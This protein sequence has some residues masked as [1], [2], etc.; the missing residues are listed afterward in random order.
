MRHFG[1]FLGYSPEQKIRKEGLGRLLAFIIN[2]ATS[3]DD[4]KLTIAC[5][6]WFKSNLLE[7]LDEHDIDPSE[8]RIITT[9][10]LPIGLKLRYS[11][12]AFVDYLLPKK[13]QKTKNLKAKLCQKALTIF[14]EVI[15]NSSALGYLFAIVVGIVLLI[16]FIL[17]LPLIFVFLILF[18]LKGIF[19]RRLGFNKILFKLKNILFLPLHNIKNNRLAI[20]LHETMRRKELNRLI[21]AINIEPEIKAWLIPTLFWPEVE[22]IKARKVIVAPDIVMYDFPLYFS[23]EMSSLSLKRLER[24][25][26]VAD[27]FITYSEYVRDSHLIMRNGVNYQDV[28]VIGHGRVDM[29]N[30]LTIQGKKQ[31]KSIEN[32]VAKEILIKFRDSSLGFNPHWSSVEFDKINY[33]FYSSQL[34][35]YKNI[36]ILLKLLTIL[37]FGKNI[38][39]KLIVTSDLYKDS[40]MVSYIIN[41]KLQSKVLSAYDIPSEVLAAFNALATLSV[42]PTLFEGGFPFTFCEAFSVG[43]P[44]IMSDIPVVREKIALISTELQK[45]MLFDPYDINDLV[46]KVLWALEHRNTLFEMQKDL[47]ESY[48]TWAQVAHQYINVLTKE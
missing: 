42:T 38:N 36:K 21:D 27:R 9:K 37:N 46:D 12:K 32:E 34:R 14:S 20:A 8:I 4:V 6:F 28:S 40:D 22:N 26:S 11:L 18:S 7:L 48:P 44:S 25:I 19:I 31:N 39:I 13:K 3:L 10:A 17:T 1:I 43:T 15:S 23:D 2:G 33:I 45:R 16:G 24:S 41:N 29:S 35:G 5:P 47:Y 30:Y